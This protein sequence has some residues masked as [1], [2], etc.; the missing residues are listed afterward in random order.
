[1]RE[2]YARIEHLLKDSTDEIEAYCNENEWINEIKVYV[3][4][5]SVKLVLEWKQIGAFEIEEQLNKI[6]NWIE[7]IKTNIEKLIITKNKILQIDT[8]SIEAFLV[9]RLDSIYLEICECL[10]KEVNTDTLSFI[11]E[12]TKI[13]DELK[14]RPKSIEEFAKYAKK[15]SKYKSNSG[16]YESKINAIKALL[17]VTST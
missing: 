2:Y 16:L 14:E 9:P 17:D 13:I 12:M 5:W 6:K 11:A 7:M 1:M 3:T 4:K 15:T 8:T 10:T